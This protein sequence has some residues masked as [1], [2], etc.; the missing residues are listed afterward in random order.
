M[1]DGISVYQLIQPVLFEFLKSLVE[2]DRTG[3]KSTVIM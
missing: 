1:A 2:T 3:V